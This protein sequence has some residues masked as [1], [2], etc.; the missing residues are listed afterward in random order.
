MTLTSEAGPSTWGSDAM[1][2][3]IRETG[4]P[5]LTLTPGASFRGLHDSL[6]NLLGNSD[7]EMLLC[8]HEEH[9]VAIAHGYAKVAG[10]PLAAV[11]HSNVGLMHA[12]M[13]VF[14]AYADRTPVLL[15]GADGPADATR[16]RPWIDWLHTAADLGSL[17]RGFVKWDDHASSPG[18]AVSSILRGYQLTCAAPTA[19]TFIGLDVAA[20]E[21]EIDPATITFPKLAPYSAPCAATHELAAAAQALRAAARVV[22]LAGRVS[23][24]QQDWERR[25]RLVEGLGARVITH[26][27]LGAAFPTDHPAHTGLP[28]FKLSP[29]D[30]ALLA[31]ADVI[32]SLDWLDLGGTLQTVSFDQ[33][34]PRT[35]VHVSLEH[36]LAN[37][38]NKLDFTPPEVDI[39]LTTSPDLAVAELLDL[40]GFT[41]AAATPAAGPAEP[42]WDGELPSHITNTFL[43]H[44]LRAATADQPV[45]LIRVPF[46][47]DFSQW[48]LRDPLDY[49]GGDGGGGVGGGPGMAVGAALAL[50]GSD[51]LPVAVLGDGDFLMGATA[52]WTAAH[53]DIPLLVVVGNNSSYYNDEIHQSA[54]AITRGRPQAN[55]H[56]GLRIDDPAPDLAGLARAQ[57]FTSFGPHTDAASLAETLREAVAIVR[58]GGRAFLDVHVQRGY[59]A[60]S[61]KAD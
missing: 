9:A 57:G 28:S 38:A 52:L 53:H 43:Q 47:W 34:K 24:D 4:V 2:L 51:R 42:S 11:V 29:A 13:A 41:G 21:T 40:M 6:V 15:I 12:S 35:I 59:A 1:A 7:P 46:G 22:V 49:L 3:A 20:Q 48:P 56:I 54:V 14:N 31:E 61:P 30:Q 50:R 44:S 5:Y 37:G 26:H 45:T 25:I 33:T 18:A 32:L 10:R 55:A 23:R 60:T 58:A 36:L 8:L 16:R 17:I 27:K 19:P 39:T